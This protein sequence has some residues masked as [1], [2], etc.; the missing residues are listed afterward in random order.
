MGEDT[1]T[2]VHSGHGALAD[3]GGKSHC[4]CHSQSNPYLLLYSLY[5]CLGSRSR[6]RASSTKS[7]TKTSRPAAHNSSVAKSSSRARHSRCSIAMSSSVSAR[8]MVTP[9]SLIS[10]SLPPNATTPIPTTPCE[11]TSTCTQASGGGRHRY[12]NFSC[13]AALDP[14]IYPIPESTREGEPWCHGHPY[15]HFLRQD[16]AHGL[17]QQD[18]IPCLSY[19]RKPPQGDPPQALSPRADPPRVHPI[20]PSRAHH[21]QSRPPAHARE[22]L[23]RMPISNTKASS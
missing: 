4:C 15:Y 6:T 19:D 12:V 23:P 17:W 21:Q 1:W 14:L 18:S 20:N 2:R 16:P 5:H 8:S 22:S 13:T 7:S 11:C 3:R 10:S 9:S